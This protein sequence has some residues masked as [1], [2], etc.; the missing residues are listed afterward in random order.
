MI[1]KDPTLGNAIFFDP[2][3]G[4]GLVV[5]F[6]QPAKLEGILVGEIVRSTVTQRVSS[7]IVKRVLGGKNRGRVSR[8]ATEFV[9]VYFGTHYFFAI[10]FPLLF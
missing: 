7:G 8:W 5:S 4:A 3:D 9:L 1:E 6:E 10:F 2:S